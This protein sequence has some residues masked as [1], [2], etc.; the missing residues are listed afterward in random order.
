M[1]GGVGP[2]GPRAGGKLRLDEASV[3][4]RVDARTEAVRGF[5]GKYKDYWTRTLPAELTVNVGDWPSVD[6]A[7]ARW[8]ATARSATLRQIRRR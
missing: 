7:S 8:W 6:P 3:A 5:V 1:A 4:A 2:H